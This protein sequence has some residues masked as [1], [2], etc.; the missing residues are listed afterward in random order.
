MELS[1]RIEDA[2]S[3]FGIGIVEICRP[4]GFN[5]T[6]RMWAVRRET[7]EEFNVCRKECNM[8]I[9]PPTQQQSL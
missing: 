5:K 4:Y 3:I 2:E 6:K 8:K 9:C 1:F 7:P